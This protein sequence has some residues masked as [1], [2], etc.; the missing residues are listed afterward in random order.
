VRGELRGNLWKL[1]YPV[2]YRTTTPGGTP[3]LVSGEV[4]EWVMS[5]VYVFGLSYYF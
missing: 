1:S 2:S 5:P 4:A 3:I